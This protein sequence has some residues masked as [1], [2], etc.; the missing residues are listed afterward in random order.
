MTSMALSNPSAGGGRRPE[1][2]AM[3]DYTLPKYT[4]EERKDDVTRVN[5]DEFV[6][7]DVAE[8]DDITIGSKKVKEEI[9]QVAQEYFARKA[10]L[11]MQDARR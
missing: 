3:D 6:R 5:E 10:I 11:N 2:V 1:N 4:H 9:G 8:E 7:E